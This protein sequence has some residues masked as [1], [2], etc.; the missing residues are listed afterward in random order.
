ME[1]SW[2]DG[3][4][5]FCLKLLSLFKIEGKPV[6]TLV[7]EGQLQIFAAIVLKK[8]TRINIITPTQ[9]GKSLIV[10][11]AC[12]ILSCIDGE[13][14]SIPAP[15]E[16]KARII[17]RYYLQH[18]GD[19]PLF[20]SQLVKG[21][22]LDRLV[23]E[24]SRDRLTLKNRGGIFILSVHATDSNKGFQAA[25]GEGSRIIIEDEACLI[26]DEIESTIFRMIAG[27]GKDTLYVKISNPFYRNHFYRSSIDERYLQIKIDYIQGLKEGRLQYEFIEEARTK[28]NFD[29]LYGCKFPSADAIGKDGYSQLLTEEELQKSQVEK[30]SHA[31]L[32][33]MGVDPAAGGDN[34]AI[35][36]KSANHQEVLFNQKLDD[37][38]D[39]VGVTADLYRAHGAH[40]IVV[41]RGGIGEGVYRRLS[42]M[43][44]PTRG[45]NFAE[46]PD[47]DFFQNKKAE[48]YWKQ[49][50]WLLGG[51][52]LMKDPSWHEF[53]LIKY[54]NK[55]GKIIIQPKEELFKQGYASPNVVDAAVLTQ[56]VSQASIKQDQIRRARGGR[57][58]HDS[59]DDMM[60]MPSTEPQQAPPQNIWRG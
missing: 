35:V 59:W 50:T 30:Q 32:I 52:R 25:M 3:E 33:T 29:I 22:K 1:F 15:S 43:G 19:H 9:Y 48:L 56:I 44:F 13:M 5:D 28:P 46:K 49:R 36:I 41:D 21:D 16:D 57:G 39:L 51:G 17:M 10:A 4:R 54:K 45:I 2:K 23:M 26:P 60:K 18:L 7:T 38:M 11:L 34:S 8:S 24:T 14:V 42:E 40:M 31:G 6:D 27:K 58:F 53:S 12:L 37:V 20:Y 47:E 55:D